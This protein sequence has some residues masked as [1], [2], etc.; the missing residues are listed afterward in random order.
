MHEWIDNGAQLFIAL[1]REQ[2][3]LVNPEHAIGEG[4]VVGFVLELADI[5]VG[6]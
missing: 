4:P 2:E 3:Q 5:G 1:G 6:L